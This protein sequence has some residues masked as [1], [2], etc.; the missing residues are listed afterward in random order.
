MATIKLVTKKENRFNKEMNVSGV[1]VTVNSKGVAE[2]E[3]KDVFRLLTASFE[4][5]DPKQKFQS[6]DQAKLAVDIETA[7]TTAKAEAVKI[8]S[9]AKAEAVKIISDAK[10]EAELALMDSKTRERE[11][12]RTKLENLTEDQLKEQLATSKVDQKNYKDLD[13]AG[14]IDLTLKLAFS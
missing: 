10:A 9:D 6:E 14:L 3:E 13:K 11:E 7:L 5:V 8:I 4:L 12:L 2:V 1:E